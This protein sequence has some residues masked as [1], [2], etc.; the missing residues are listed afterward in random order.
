MTVMFKSENFSALFYYANTGPEVMPGIV[1]CII[2]AVG[3][4]RIIGSKNEII[5]TRKYELYAD[6]LENAWMEASRIILRSERKE[7]EKK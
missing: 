6:N 7:L 1:R 2:E 4:S 3:G 5:P